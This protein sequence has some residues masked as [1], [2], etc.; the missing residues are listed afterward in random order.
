MNFI[1]I[2]RPFL[3]EE[4]R[5]AVDEVLSSG[6]LTDSSL[7][8]G[9]W[10][11]NFE[12]KVGTLLGV[13]HVIAVNSGTAA[14]HSTLLA[15]GIKNG[16]EVIIPS[17]TFVATANVVL[18]CGAKPV[19]VDTKAD[20]NIDPAEVAKKITKKTKAIL[21][22]HV[23]GYPADLDELK[24]IAEGHNLPLIEDAAESLGAEYKGKQTGSTTTA[25]CFSL[26]ATKVI[27]S[28][29]G[30]AVSTT[31]EELARKLRMVRNHGMVKGY[32][33]RVLGLNLR[34]PEV[35]AAIASV[36][37]DRLPSFLQARRRNAASLADQTRDLGGIEMTQKARDRNHVWYLFTVN[38]KERRDEVMA[39]MRQAGVG[40]SVYWEK[41]VHKTPY[42]ISLGF[43]KT[44]LPNTEKA[45]KMV[46]SLPVHPGVSPEQI[47]Y[48]AARLK[49]T[50][51][52]L[53]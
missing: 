5:K 29:E 11:R 2:N 20:Y 10:V 48:I 9:K 33:T 45:A 3:G 24:E 8:G 18:A 16:D 7:E 44:K 36:Q 32:D 1:P 49:D 27:T 42:Y 30:G 21:P 46:L 19:F 51:R 12:S 34:L 47:D 53:L 22:V 13:K 6:L 41:P 37:M 23:Y 25:G 31:D 50:L 4:E 28:G 38:V 40:A 35:Q 39:R 43:S 14:L 17:F 52:D 26:Y 15:C